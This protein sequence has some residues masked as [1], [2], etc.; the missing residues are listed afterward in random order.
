[1]RLDSFLDT[2]RWWFRA[3]N[4]VEVAENENKTSARPDY[5][6]VNDGSIRMDDVPPTSLPSSKST[7][8]DTP[9]VFGFEGEYSII[10]VRETAAGKL[11][12]E[13]M[14][15]RVGRIVKEMERVTE[16][17]FKYVFSLLPSQSPSILRAF[18]SQRC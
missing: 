8:T 18:V 9:I 7:H 13:E 3:H 14:W 1:V 17:K 12:I 11:G 6:S 5:S 15:K 10:S 4:S 16:L 2:F